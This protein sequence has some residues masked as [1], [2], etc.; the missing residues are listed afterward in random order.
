MKHLVLNEVRRGMFVLKPFLS[1]APF[2]KIEFAN[3]FSFPFFIFYFWWWGE[4]LMRVYFLFVFYSVLPL[5]VLLFWGNRE[6]S[7]RQEPHGE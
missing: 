4:L 5:D 7:R 1:C 6:G 3:T 2:L